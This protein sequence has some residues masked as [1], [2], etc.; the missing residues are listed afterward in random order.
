M[1]RLYVSLL[2]TVSLVCSMSLYSQTTTESIKQNNILTATSF[3]DVARKVSPNVVSIRLKRSIV[4]SFGQQ[5][6]HRP[7]LIVPFGMSD[8]LREQLERML[9]EQYL[10]LYPG[11]PKEKS[12]VGSGSGVI[13]HEDGYII[14]SYHVIANCSPDNIEVTLAD[15]TRYDKADIIGYDEL[16]DI[17]I[18]K[19]DGGKMKSSAVWG[20]SD[21]L[22][23]GDFVVAIGNSLDFSNSISEGIISAKH[24]VI[25]KTPIEDLIQTTAMIN[26]GNSGGA[27]CN[28][29]GE[30]I[31]I[32]MAIATDTG[33][34]S[35]VGFAIPSRIAKNVSDQIMSKGY[36][37]RGFLGI[38]M[39]LINTDLAKQINYTKPYGIMITNVTKGEPADRAGLKRYD[40]I[41]KVDGQEIKDSSDIM[42]IVGGKNSGDTVELEVYKSTNENQASAP[43]VI[44]I[45]LSERPVAKPTIIGKKL[46]ASTGNQLLG[47]DVKRQPDGKGL[48]VVSV[49]PQSQSSD[50]GINIGD[51][52]YEVNKTPVN[53]EDE[54]RNA[55]SQQ[56]SNETHLVYLERNKQ[57][58]FVQIPT[59]K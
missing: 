43:E 58:V 35:G 32:N 17:G 4:S 2:L 23:P 13:I 11:E 39:S 26:P 20:D 28:L 34:W 29:A 24:R 27:L 38:G 44:K 46:N 42:K 48:L 30:V 57:S 56:V 7:K 18:I 51:I 9:D 1:K 40:I 16:T 5:S 22:E 25:K 41:A 36:V 45:Q 14:T 54:L 59:K 8:E 3:R 12:Y 21:S 6:A 19:I 49:D 52:I 50:A 55:F 15:G 47:L 33:L 10:H 31:G 53:S 37:S